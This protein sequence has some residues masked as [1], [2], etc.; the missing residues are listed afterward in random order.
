L[1]QFPVD[2][3]PVESVLMKSLYSILDAHEGDDADALKK[4]FRRVVKAHHPDLHPDDPDAPERFRQIIAAHALL[5]DAKR[6]ATYDRLLL[7]ERQQLRLKVEGHLRSKLAHQ[8]VRLKRMRAIAAVAALGALVGGYGLFFQVSRTADNV[9]INKDGVAAA[10]V[11]TAKEDGQTAS[12]I[13]VAERN[14][15]TPTAVA[16]AKSDVVKDNSE[17]NVDNAGQPLETTGAQVL[18]ASGALDR[19]EPSNAQSNARESNAAPPPN[20]GNF[21]RERGIAAYGNGDFLGAIGNFDEAIRLNP[22]DAQSYNMRGNV[23]DELGR[24]EPALADY[25]EAIRIDPNNPAVFRDRAILWQRKG[26]LDKA[27]G[28]LDRAIRFSFA[29]AN[30]YCDRGLMW[31]QK[32]R[33]GRAIADFDR[34]IRLDPNFAAACINRGL[35]LHRKRQFNVAFADNKAIHVDP[36]I[37]DVSRH[38]NAPR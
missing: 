8:Q 38:M 6:R 36:G 3:P 35:V 24:F 26:A 14:E 33:H 32:G 19:G 1:S 5:G 25:N 28:D 29:D 20:D 34:A 7:V 17:S 30:L 15:N 13:L 21:Y 10:A 4:A 18:Q 22:D 9:T 12:A 11:A 23:W 31:Y 37:F 16:A 27:L 2:S